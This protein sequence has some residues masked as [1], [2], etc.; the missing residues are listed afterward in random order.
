EC[1]RDSTKCSSKKVRANPDHDKVE[2]GGKS[3]CH[4]CANGSGEQRRDTLINIKLV[5]GLRKNPRLWSCGRPSPPTSH[6][7]RWLTDRSSEACLPIDPYQSSRWHDWA[8]N[9]RTSTR[10]RAGIAAS[11]AEDYRVLRET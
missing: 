4:G 9:W 1:R 10:L 7:C 3:H 2:I 5:A 8:M 11:S 6:V